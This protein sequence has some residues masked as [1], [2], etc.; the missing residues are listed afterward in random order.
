MTLYVSWRQAL[1][2]RM[3]R[4]LLDPVGTLPVAGVVRRLC[5]VQTQVASSAELAIRLRRERSRSGEVDRALAEGRLI[6]TWAMRG[7]LHLLT[8]EEGGAFLS[9]IAEGRR[10]EL[11]SW[12]R[13]SGLTPGVMSLYRDTVREALDGAPLTREELIAALVRRRRLRHL[14]EGLRSGWGTLFKPLAWLGDLCHGPS[15]GARVTFTRPA[16]ASPRWAGLPDPDEAGPVALR[17]YLAAYGPATMTN[18]GNWLRAGTG[19]RRLRAAFSALGNA[20]AEVRVDGGVPTSWLKTS[21][22]SRLRGQP[23]LCGC[24]PASTSTCWVP[25]L[26]IITRCRRSGA[27]P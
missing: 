10:W 14:G 5:A 22:R 3:Q 17:A 21:T 15:R 4:Q 1:A 2:W 9:L 18:F 20:L 6:K 19:R 25:G 27:S 13:Y 11:P 26:T 16:A 23:Q 7:A 8:P 24:C 12:Q